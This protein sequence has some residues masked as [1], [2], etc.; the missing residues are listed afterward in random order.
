MAVRLSGYRLEL[1]QRSLYN[2][3]SKGADSSVF[4]AVSSFICQ[5]SLSYIARPVAKFLSEFVY[6]VL[7]YKLG[8]RARLGDCQVETDSQDTDQYCANGKKIFME[9]TKTVM[10]V[11][12]GLTRL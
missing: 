9:M 5:S 6:D 8:I 4:E 11:V 2:S 12:R 3:P 7:K 10:T 1:L